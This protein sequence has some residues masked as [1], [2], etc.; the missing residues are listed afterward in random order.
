MHADGEHGWLV[1]AADA[2]RQRAEALFFV[3]VPESTSY[4]LLAGPY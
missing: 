2:G 3:T 4:C 1:D